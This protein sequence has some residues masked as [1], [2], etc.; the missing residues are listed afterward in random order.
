MSKR[1]LAGVVIA[2]V[3]S[4]AGAAQ[5]ASSP[6]PYSVQEVP[7]AW[8]ADRISDRVAETAAGVIIAVFPSSVSDTGPNYE[9][10]VTRAPA[11]SG[12]SSHAQVR[13]PQYPSSVSDTGPNH[14]ETSAA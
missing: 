11:R 5:A 12:A 1:K 10:S 7:A 9:R 6:F 4:V 3:L 14:I 2:G 13:V 8:Y